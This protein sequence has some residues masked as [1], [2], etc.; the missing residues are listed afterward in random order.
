M[1]TINFK[2]DEIDIKIKE[3]VINYLY[4]KID[5]K[6][7]R[8]S[9]IKNNENIMNIKKSKYYISANYGGIPSFLVF[10]K[11]NSN[12]YCYLIDR[13]SISFDKS[14]LNKNNNYNLNNVRMTKIKLSV[15][16]DLY[17]GTIM[18]CCLIDKI[19]NMREMNNYKEKNKKLQIMINDIFFLCDNNL[20]KM[21]YKKKIFTSTCFLKNNYK[22]NE[23]DN[24]KL[25]ITPI[26]EI[27]QIQELYKNYIKP[28]SAIFNI[29]GIAIYPTKSSNKLI[30]ICN[31]EDNEYKEELFNNE[32]N[33][34]SYLIETTNK[35]ENENKNKNENE[36]KNEN[37]NKN[38]Y[39]NNI[40]KN[41]DDINNFY[42]K[43]K[44]TIKYNLRDISYEG[45]IKLNFE[46]IKHDN[47]PDI[48][49]LYGLY[50]YNNK[51][52][53]KNSGIAYIP[54]YNNSL[55]CKNIFMNEKK[56]IMECLFCPSKCKWIP[57]KKA[58]INKIH[59]INN[60]NRLIV[61]DEICLDNN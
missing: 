5:V 52:Y 35:N 29:K 1:N 11:N 57:L 49:T 21:N 14:F 61:N 53:K 19:S 50:I 25:F 2:N 20:L 51:I 17:D 26:Y 12:F 3:F 43:V 22:F 33:F 31:Q 10:L 8:F 23:I 41:K 34:D 15:N 7:Y 18:D 59:I 40:K 54:D 55:L 24:A 9:I 36:Y 13:R 37:E 30:Y 16:I 39:K 46:V 4:S 45:E 48:Y 28:F 47:I 32:I 42:E 44:K 38:E 58:L 6:D 27:N 60:D 56:I